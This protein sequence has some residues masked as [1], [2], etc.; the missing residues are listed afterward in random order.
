[1]P[2]SSKAGQIPSARQD[3]SFAALMLD[4][5]QRLVGKP[6]AP[7]PWASN[8]TA[9]TW[10]YAQAPF[11]LLAAD[12]SADP[13][14]VYA[15]QTAQECFG[16]D[17][18][19]FIGLLSRLSAPSDAQEDR[20]MLLRS[21]AEHGYSTGYRGR[22]VAKSGQILWIED[23]TVWNLV[24]NDGTHHGQAAVFHSWSYT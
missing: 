7:R 5:H 22:R 14:F 3:P 9:A 12:S 13:R 11:V 15:N 19:E 6:L 10:L 1:M 2:S 17:W 16:Y 24:A 4:S 23:A 20:D 21:V 18:G 8:A